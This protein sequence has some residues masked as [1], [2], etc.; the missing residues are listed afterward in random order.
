MYSTKMS[1][2]ERICVHE[3]EIWIFGVFFMNRRFLIKL[4]TTPFMF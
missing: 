4:K 2:Q 1:N 3:D